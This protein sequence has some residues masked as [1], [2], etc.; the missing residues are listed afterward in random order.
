MSAASSVA[1]PVP[2]ATEVAGAE[3]LHAAATI[4]V[5]AVLAVAGPVPAAVV[6]IAIGSLELITATEIFDI[7]SRSSFHSSVCGARFLGA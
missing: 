4:P 2:A 7:N 1:D 3:P 5:S 6:T